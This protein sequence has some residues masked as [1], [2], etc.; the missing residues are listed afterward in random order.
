M[1]PMVV[2]LEVTVILEGLLLYLQFA[3]MRHRP[4]GWYNPRSVTS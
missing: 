3:N 1:Q 4:G 2:I